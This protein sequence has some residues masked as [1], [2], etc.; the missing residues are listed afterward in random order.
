MDAK[1]MFLGLLK[2]HGF[3][4]NFSVA[5][6]SDSPP[7]L[8]LV[9]FDPLSKDQ[10]TIYYSSVDD[11]MTTDFLSEEFSLFVYEDAVWALR[12]IIDE[13]I[14]GHLEREAVFEQVEHHAYRLNRWLRRT[15]KAYD[16]N[17]SELEDEEPDSSDD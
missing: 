5:M 6:W 14:P 4:A 17:F 13:E 2:I 1:T 10:V 12:D 8:G 16:A 7:E 11:P 3:Y 15:S 9:L